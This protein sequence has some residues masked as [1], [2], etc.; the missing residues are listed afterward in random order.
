MQREEDPPGGLVRR[1]WEGIEPVSLQI[2]IDTLVVKNRNR[3]TVITGP[4]KTVYGCGPGT[5]DAKI[6]VTRHHSGS[7]ES[8]RRIR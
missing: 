3:R 2:I 4:L 8:L 7:T 1:S 5:K 6:G